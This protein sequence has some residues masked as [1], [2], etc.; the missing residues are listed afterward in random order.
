LLV[1]NH[2]GV[3]F[4]VKGP[5]LEDAIKQ[6]SSSRAKNSSGHSSTAKLGSPAKAI[7]A[8]LGSSSNSNSSSAAQGSSSTPASNSAVAAATKQST[9]QGSTAAADSSAV[10]GIGNSKA[11]GSDGDLVQKMKMK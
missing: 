1:C 4:Y 10:G 2:A 7:S 3:G 11:E 6:F 5:A 9:S 8:T